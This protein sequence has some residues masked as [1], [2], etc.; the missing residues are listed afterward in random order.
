MLPCS[1]SWDWCKVRCLNHLRRTRSNPFCQLADQ[2]YGR[3]P[4]LTDTGH[5]A[6][7][8]GR[9]QACARFP[10]P[11]RTFQAVT[12]GHDQTDGGFNDRWGRFR[13]PL[14]YL[15]QNITERTHKALKTA[16]I[17]RIL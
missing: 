12:K 10:D 4:Y 8:K 16:L 9:D 13:Y 2:D 7:N 1:W 5:Q 11:R 3:C 15:R 17:E 14:D 6:G